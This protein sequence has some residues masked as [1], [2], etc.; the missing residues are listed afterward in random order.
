MGV[1]IMDNLRVLFVDDEEELVSTVVERLQL[2][3][4]DARGALSG[5]EALRLIE[6]Q[7]FDVVVLD[8]KMP[9]LGGL[10]VIKR[11]KQERPDLVVI[12]LTGHGSKDSAEESLRMGAFACLMKPID[13]EALIKI[14]HKAA[15][16]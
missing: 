1:E 12:F 5:A 4:I 14:L 8:V 3:K 2:R 16:A 7:V 9:G 10:E 6:E 11:I 13:I 15:N